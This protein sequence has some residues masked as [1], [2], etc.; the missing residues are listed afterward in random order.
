MPDA[1]PVTLDQKRSFGGA[2]RGVVEQREQC[3]S[4][5]AERRSAQPQRAVRIALNVTQVP[6]P[7]KTVP[8]MR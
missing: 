1:A 7:S 3:R 2:P 8:L 5:L 6:A 4:V